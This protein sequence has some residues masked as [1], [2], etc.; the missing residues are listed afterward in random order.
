MSVFMAV[1]IGLATGLVFGFA[2][3]KSRVF[4]PG[5]IVGQMQM[6]NFI[7]LKV[8]LAA[9][10]T[11]LLVL[12]VLHGLLDVK[13]SLKPLLFK[14]DLIG[15]LILGAGIALAGACPGTA[16]AQIGA[17]YRDAWFIVA[18]GIAGAVTYGYL[19][20]PITALLA[21]SGSKIGFDQ[22]LG[23][24][25]WAAACALAVL[26]AGVLWA[27]EQARPWQEDLGPEV[28]GVK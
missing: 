28:D 2:L 10:I 9:V 24:P 3:E 8:F 26:L 19:D 11:G 22:L 21:E 4:E 18:G 13:L 1:L 23:V 5:V 16:L 25:F 20:V 15:G 12:A 17:G 7:M 27:L 14:A 6:R